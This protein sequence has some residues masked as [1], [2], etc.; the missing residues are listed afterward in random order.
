MRSHGL[1]GVFFA[2]PDRLGDGGPRM[3]P[4]RPGEPAAPADSIADAPAQA[5][6]Y[7]A[8]HPGRPDPWSLRWSELKL[9]ARLCGEIGSHTASHH[10]S[11]LSD[12]LLGFLERP[13]WREADALGG[14]ARRGMPRFPGRPAL[15]GRA[16]RPA[17]GLLEAL[18]CAAARHPAALPVDSLR[19]IVRTFTQAGLAG[20]YETLAEYQARLE[21]ELGDSRA[22]LGSFLGRPVT[23]L[24]WPW[25]RYSPEL[26]ERARAAG[27]TLIFTVEPGACVHGSDSLAVPRVAAPSDTA[28]LRGALWL[29][30]HPTLGRIWGRLHPPRYPT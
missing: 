26:R 27:Y 15:L 10:F 18:A 4:A 20:R 5:D 13:T 25:G 30:S 12:S 24:A 22:R 1:H 19:A 2:L 16:F 9:L 14:D 3:L 23:A 11:F 7:A 29:Y 17:P 6:M 28:W 8:L 21:R